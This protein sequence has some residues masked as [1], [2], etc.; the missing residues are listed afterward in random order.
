MTHLQAFG[1]RFAERFFVVADVTRWMLYG[2]PSDEV[3]EGLSAFSPTYLGP[4]GGFV[5]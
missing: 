3:K 4:L 1:A 2:T 5:R